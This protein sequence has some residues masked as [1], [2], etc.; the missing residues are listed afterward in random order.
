MALT[1]HL[2]KTDSHKSVS[3]FAPYVVFET[4][5]YYCYLSSHFEEI[6]QRTGKMIDPY[7]DAVFHAV[8]LSVLEDVFSQR[9]KR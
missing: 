2:T 7:D 3:R 1:A 6:H 9:R 4:D 5:A 8:E